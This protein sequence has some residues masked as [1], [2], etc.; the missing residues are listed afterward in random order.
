MVGR[1]V[2]GSAI[3]LLALHIGSAARSAKSIRLPK[4]MFT[5][6]L[7][8]LLLLEPGLAMMALHN[9]RPR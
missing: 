3:A 1:N 9:R 5:P 4:I 7:M 6:C 2:V 8:R